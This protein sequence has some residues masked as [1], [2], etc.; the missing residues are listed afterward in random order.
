[1]VIMSCI[2]NKK[3]S[4][5]VSYA[6]R[7][8]P[9]EYE[10]ELDEHGWVY[11]SDLIDSLKRENPGWVD[12]SEDDLLVM[13]NSFDKKR[14]EIC[15]KKIRALYGHS[16]PLKLTKEK[17]VPPDV[18]FHGTTPAVVNEILKK[19][20]SP[21]GRQ[22]VHLSIDV[23]TAMQVGGRKT[24]SP[25]LLEVDA[26]HANKQGVNFYRGND[27]VWLADHVPVEYLTRVAK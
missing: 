13:S 8:A 17:A 25:I 1:M 19:G 24:K 10:L 18:L 5:K 22:Y 3:L 9:W 2:D 21:M 14:H 6:L 16:V 27:K 7:H 23:D 11:I 4:K 15:G 20:L 12:L 26:S